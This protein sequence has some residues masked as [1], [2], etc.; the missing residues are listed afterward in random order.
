M[1]IARGWQAGN[2]VRKRVGA[3]AAT[4]KR[5]ALSFYHHHHHH[6]RSR[7]AWFGRSVGPT[8]F[9]RLFS[10]R[11]AGRPTRYS[12]KVVFIGLSRIPGRPPRGMDHFF[13]SH[14]LPSLSRFILCVDNNRRVVLLV[15]SVAVR[16]WMKFCSIWKRHR[17]CMWYIHFMSNT[18]WY[19]YWKIHSMWFFFNG[20]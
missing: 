5:A 13:L 14:L 9:A 8:T 17:L 2:I 15:I 12:N 20:N 7:Q 4:A 16:I 18:V 11:S 19:F 6:L 3:G 10:V 1:V